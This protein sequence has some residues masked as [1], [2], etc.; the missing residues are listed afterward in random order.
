MPSA[1]DEDEYANLDL[2]LDAIGEGKNKTIELLT[3]VDYDKGMVIQNK[4]V[5]FALG[6]YD[7]NIVN[8]EGIGL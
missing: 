1:K 5:E 6:E 7:L 8:T 4:S 3:D 2:A